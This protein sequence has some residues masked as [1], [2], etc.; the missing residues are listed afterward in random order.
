MT[1][2]AEANFFASLIYPAEVVAACEQSRALNALASQR[3]S[4][5]RPG[6][7]RDQDLADWDA[8]VDEGKSEP[9][10]RRKS[11]AEWRRKNLVGMEDIV[12]GGVG[13]AEVA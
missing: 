2:R 12:T 4:A 3:H 5:D 6:R 13:L 10:W 9:D 7:K 1:A 11:E 8:A